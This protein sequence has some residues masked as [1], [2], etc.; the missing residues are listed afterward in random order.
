MHQPQTTKDGRQYL[1]RDLAIE[2]VRGT[3]QHGEAAE[4]GQLVAIFSWV[5]ANIEYRLDPRDYD[6]YQVAGRTINSGG[7]D[8]DDHTILNAALA[9][10]LGFI[11]GAK[12]VSPDGKNWHIYAVV[13]V[14]PITNPQHYMAMDTTQPGSHAGWEPPDAQRREEYLCTFREGKAVNLHKLSRWGLFG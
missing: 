12:I 9:S 13:G 1:I 8:C 3:P 10:S 5:K 11:S 14:H 4:D 6:Q 2:I 7:S